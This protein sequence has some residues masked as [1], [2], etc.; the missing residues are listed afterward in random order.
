VS[1]LAVPLKLKEANAFVDNFHRHNKPVQGAR[2]AI[3]A[4]WDGLLVGVAIVG[5][6]VQYKLDGNRTAE[7]LRVC[8][9]GV[10]RT[11]KDRHGEEH[12]LAV[13]SFLYQR[14]WQAWRAM[15]GTRLI[16]YTLESEPGSSLKGA[17]WRVVA[18]VPPSSGRGW[19]NRPGREWQPVHGQLKFRWEAV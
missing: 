2:F 8:T 6:P 19:T 12:T 16:T 7:V 1:L 10:D 3:G 9:D 5:R 13:C 14:C 17:G 11:T 18:E 15:G 4:E